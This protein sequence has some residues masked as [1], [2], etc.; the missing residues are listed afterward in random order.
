[1]K[2]KNAIV[3]GYFAKNL[4]DDLML[5]AFINKNKDKYEKIYINSYRKFKS[6]YSKLGVN[7]ITIDSFAYRVINKLL[8]IFR[9]ADLYY[10]LPKKNTDFIM[11]G[12]SLFAESSKEVNESQF[13]NLEYAVDHAEHSYVIGSNFGSYHSQSFLENYKTLFQKCN[14]VCFRDCYSYDLFSEMTNVR[15]APDVVFSGEWD[16]EKLHTVTSHNIIIS[17][18][19]LKNRSN[20]CGKTEEYEKKLAGIAKYHAQNGDKVILTSFCEFEGDIETCARVKQICGNESNIEIISYNDFKFMEVISSAKK[21]YGTRFHSIILALYYGIPCVPFIYNEKTHNAL[22]AY[23]QSVD[24]IDIMQL[25]NYTPEK[26][27]DFDSKIELR[28]NIKEMA[29]QQFEGVC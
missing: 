16:D 11:L 5:K 13:I 24:A 18:I 4:G 22:M 1:M 3:W 19:N 27:I 8:H 2:N 10:T 26:I 12:G 21:I 25:T 7:V 23:C 14:D 20:L 28:F 17:V 29:K 6:Y 15:Y 9:T